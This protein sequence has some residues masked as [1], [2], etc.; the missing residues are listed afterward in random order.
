MSKEPRIVAELGRPETPEET[1]ARKA[2]SRKKHF[3][4]QNFTNLMLALAASLV[5][6]VV[7]VLV[8]LRPDPPAP[9]PID[10]RAA[11]QEA[12]VVLGTE[13]IVPEVPE[14]WA[15]NAAEVR[16]SGDDVST[17]YTGYVTP[18]NEFVA[19][20]Q[21]VDAN[22]TWLANQLRNAS[23]TGEVTVGGI[24][25]QYYDQREADDAGNLEFAMTTQVDDTWVVL[26][27]TAESPEFTQFAE[28]VSA[29]I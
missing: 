5:L 23:P 15:A 2:A 7:I 25:W 26:F 22:S 13:P 24:E 28:A 9:E 27:G 4:N 12:Q 8:V 21:A 6:V 14:G 16:V 3:E 10:V 18:E 29:A 11:A 17:W 1:A 20:T 19:M